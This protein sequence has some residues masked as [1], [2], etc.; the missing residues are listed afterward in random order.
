MSDEPK[1]PQDDN[2]PVIM[3]VIVVG[4]LGFFTV[5]GAV[6]SI[7]EKLKTKGRFR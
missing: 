6:V 4:L 1:T 7:W 2:S 5:T 3:G